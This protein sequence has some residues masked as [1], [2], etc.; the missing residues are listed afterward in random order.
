[1]IDLDQIKSSLKAKL[2]EHRYAHTQMVVKTALHYCELLHKA[3]PKLITES[4]FQRAEYAAWLHDR[5]KE[6]SNEEQLKLAEFYGIEI[7]EEDRACPNLL[8]ARVGAAVIE[9]EFEVVDTI[10]LQAVRAHTLGEID[11]HPVA[12]IMYLADMLEPSRDKQL[13]D[14]A[15]EKFNTI[16]SIIIE[17]KSLDKALLAAM[18]STINYVLSCG[19]LIHPLGVVARNSLVK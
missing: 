7:Y 6:L 12:K 4:D 13:S 17:E 16:R 11:M 9:E 1:M 10:V 2:S 8:H 5:C 3:N 14:K 19:Q 18:D 15:I